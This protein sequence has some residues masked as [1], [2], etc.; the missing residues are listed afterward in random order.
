[1][2]EAIHTSETSDVTRASR[3]NISE[4]GILDSHRR[5][6]LNSYLELTGWTLKQRGNVHSLRYELGFHIP[7]D[8]IYHSHRLENLKSYKSRGFPI[9]VNDFGPHPRII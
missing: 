3:R 6:N 1:M 9:R 2:M 4:N 8:G 7:E 5:E